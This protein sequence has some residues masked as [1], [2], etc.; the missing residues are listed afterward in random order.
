METTE[1]LTVPPDVWL[2]M[3]SAG[4]G[5]R[6]SH[7][8]DRAANPWSDILAAELIWINVD[9]AAGDSGRVA[10]RATALPAHV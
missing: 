3:V 9:L 8:V 7:G 2:C 1:P 5:N 10:A 6:R 4:A